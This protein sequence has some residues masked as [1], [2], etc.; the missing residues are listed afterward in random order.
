M[1]DEGCTLIYPS[2]FLGGVIT[3]IDTVVDNLIYVIVC[4]NVVS[5]W[6]SLQ[7]SLFLGLHILLLITSMSKNRKFFQ[8]NKGWLFDKE[9]KDWLSEN[10]KSTKLFSCKWCRKHDL[11]L[12]DTGKASLN[13]HMKS[14]KHTDI[15]NA[16]NKNG[17][18]FSKQPGPLGKRPPLLQ[19]RT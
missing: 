19:I 5:S 12:S 16:R 8:F 1:I 15:I 10:R 2:L 14:A 11:K 18:H 9:Y 4:W 7:F 13:Q 17:S 6:Y 3:Y